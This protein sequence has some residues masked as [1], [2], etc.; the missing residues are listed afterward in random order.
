MRFYYFSLFSWLAYAIVVAVVLPLLWLVWTRILKLKTAKPAFWVLIAAIVVGPWVEE[1]WIAYNF[2]R[3]CRRDAGVFVNK[4]LEVDGFYDS[5]MRSGYEITK[6]AHFK[7]VEHPTED[8]KGTER[9]ELATTAERDMALRW[10]AERN[11][12]SERP[13]DRSVFHPLSD[14]ETIAVLPNGVDAWKITKLEKPTARYHFRSA[15]SHQAI[16]AAHKI[17]RE[18]TSVVDTQTGELVG[19]YTSYARAPYWF[20]MSLGPGSYGCDGPDGGP[21][22]KHSS[23]IYNQVFKP[24]K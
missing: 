1:L 5:T 17:W 8:R 6:R 14:R 13:K 7:F 3:L 10:Y 19:R 12:G 2:D 16:R 24:T 4:T 18:E 23:L 9:V 20:Y 15:T 11:P 21:N 22:T